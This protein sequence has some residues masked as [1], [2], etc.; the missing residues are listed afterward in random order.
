MMGGTGPV[1]VIGGGPAGLS[2]AYELA[3]RGVTVAVHEREDRV[4]GI[5]RTVTHDGYRFDIGGHRFLTKVP[6]VQQL[7]ESVMGDE[8]IT[9]QRLSRIYYQKRFFDYPISI[10]N[11]VRNLGLLES[12]LS[13]GSYVHARIRREA[14]PATFEQWV[15]GRFGRRLYR[16]FFATYT[17]KVWGIPGSEI[18]ADWAAQRIKGLSVR[19]ALRQAVVGDSEV[20]SLA[21]AFRYP[22]LGVGQMWERI[23]ARVEA[24]GGTVHLE[25]TV[26]RIR[27]DGRRVI[28]VEAEGRDGR[29]TYE[30]VGHV[31]SSAPLGS[32]IERLAPP[33]PPDVLEAA[34]GLRYRDFILVG[35]ILDVPTAFPDNWIYV[36]SPDVKVGR[37]QNFRNWSAEMVPDAGRT[38]LGMEYFCSKGDTLWAMDDQALLALAVRE[39]EQLELGSSAH[40]VDGCVVRQRRAYPVYD[41]SYRERVQAIRSYLAGIGNLQTIGRNG[42]H[43]YNNQDHSTVAGLMAARNILGERHDVWNINTDGSY[44]E[45]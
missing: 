30:D 2:A 44:L 41:E 11:V 22:R 7:W 34:R 6:E 5:A 24:A 15:T 10:P 39:L 26:K 32:L 31:I 42:T 23:A 16:T 1:I 18:R 33:P 45:A 13:F 25:S 38:S 21:R 17:E 29:T 43:R 19:S 27:H 8:F 36:H 20:M 3:A 12:A 14:D 4:G 37:V 40:V 28:A 9:V 35:L